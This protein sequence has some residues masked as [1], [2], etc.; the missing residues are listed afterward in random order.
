[1]NKYEQAYDLTTIEGV[2]SFIDDYPKLSNA[3]FWANDFEISDM[4]M[5]FDIAIEKA[6]TDRQRQVVKLSC[7]DMI[8]VDI[9]KYLGVTQQTTQEHLKRAVIKIAEYHQK[10]KERGEKE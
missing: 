9:A 1:M 7:A 5:D 4:L 2:E 8:Q 6:L 10:E 3:R